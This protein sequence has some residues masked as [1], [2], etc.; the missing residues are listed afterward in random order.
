MISL[1]KKTL[2]ET[3]GVYFYKKG[4]A[5]LYVG[6]A[7][8]LKKRVSSYFHASANLSPAKEKLIKEATNLIWE[9]TSSEIE[10]LLL[11]AHYIKK[12][13]PP[14]NVLLRDDKT[15]LSV[16]ITD[17]E[18][19]RILPTRKIGNEGTYF[20]P[21]TDTRAVKETLRVL[22]KMFPYRTNCLPE[23]GRACL[24]AH[25]GLC[26]GVC[27]GSISA[28][29]YQKN[30]R[31]IKLFFE[32]KRGR[33]VASLKRE[34]KPLK[35]HSYILENVRMTEEERIRT[36]YKIQRLEQ[37]I[38]WLEKVITMTHVLQQSEKIEGDVVELGNQ[39]ELKEPP[40]R[41]EGYDISHVSGTLTT[42]SMVVFIDGAADKSEYKKF[43][44]K[45]VRGAN[46]VASLKEVFRR[47]F[48]HRLGG[49]KE[50]WPMPDLVVVDGGRPQL[51]AALEVWREL[52]LTVPL[53]SLAKR[54]EEIFVPG[55]VDSIVL[56][57]T[58]PALHLV[59]RVR[60]EAHRFCKSYHTLLRH[61]KLMQR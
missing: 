59:E 34:L 15:F 9:E 39:L 26:P 47:R 20:G 45:T 57:R 22:R 28:R 4:R 60:D 14:Y 38:Q 53:I 29:E 11:E 12:H 33:V 8:N 1:D 36:S 31:R 58:S 55:R 42:A 25:I 23:S 13:R 44:I 37:Q 3:P 30:V 19:P 49:E 48:A 35:K 46:D 16:V 6:K 10:A 32:G 41:I 40:H 21:F 18:Y 56:P 52:K 61:K 2:P 17:E 43:K 50:A 5:V 54:Y 7:S 24:D 51:G 27:A